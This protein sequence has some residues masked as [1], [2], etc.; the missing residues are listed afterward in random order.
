MEGLTRF[1]L[2]YP[3]AGTFRRKDYRRHAPSYLSLAFVLPRSS[4]PCFHWMTS[5]GSGKE[6]YFSICS[7][8]N[9]LHRYRWIPA[10]DLLDDG[11][12]KDGS[13]PVLPIVIYL[14]DESS[15]SPQSCSL[16]KA[17]PSRAWLLWYKPARWCTE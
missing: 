11:R 7:R 4:L 10:D 2:N 1:L 17:M 12:R 8:Q 9:R 13:P 3:S 14:V 16:F 15:P 5:D 6:F